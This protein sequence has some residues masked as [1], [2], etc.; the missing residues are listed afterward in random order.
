MRS[1]TRVVSTQSELRSLSSRLCEGAEPSAAA[2]LRRQCSS[3]GP[4]NGV[5]G[6]SGPRADTAG[7]RPLPPSPLPRASGRRGTRMRGWR[8]RRPAWHVM[9]GGRAA[10][11]R[12]PHASHAVPARASP[13]SARPGARGGERHVP[14]PPPLLAN[15]RL[16]LLGSCSKAPKT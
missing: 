4:R 13:G 16:R 2:A 7:T 8:T 1:A 10:R 3:L 12:P 5:G 6:G 15:G 11:P 9:G 14:P